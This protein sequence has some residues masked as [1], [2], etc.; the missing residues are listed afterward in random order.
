MGI[1]NENSGITI[2]LHIQC[3]SFGRNIIYKTNTKINNV[4]IIKLLI[5]NYLIDMCK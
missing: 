3:A 5:N 1:I 2:P 4:D